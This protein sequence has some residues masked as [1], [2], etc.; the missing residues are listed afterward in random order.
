MRILV[1]VFNH[2]AYPVFSVVLVGVL[3]YLLAVNGFSLVDALTVAAAVVILF[4]IWRLLVSTETGELDSVRAVREE[5][6][7]GRRPTIIEFFSSYCVGCMAMKPVVDRL[8]AEAGD[9]LQ[10]IRLNIDTE[11]G[12]TLMSE[13]GVVFTPTF[14]YFDASGN[15]LR[16]SIGVLDRARVLYDLETP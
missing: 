6:S 15:K 2:R 12:K 8:E 7:N 11:P 9:R 5:L 3:T 10:I 1:R 16:E 13:F 14:V 4:I